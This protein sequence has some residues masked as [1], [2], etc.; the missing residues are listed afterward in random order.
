MEESN[1]TYHG[2][3]EHEISISIS[4][5]NSKGEPRCTVKVR[6]KKDEVDTLV[7]LAQKKFN[8]LL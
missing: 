6:G 8:E 2:Y 1:V 7:S 5:D 3:Q 4:N